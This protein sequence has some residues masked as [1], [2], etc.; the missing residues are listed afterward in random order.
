VSAPYHRAGEAILATI[1][2]FDGTET[3]ARSIARQRQVD[4][5]V[6]CRSSQETQALRREAPGGFLDQLAQ[7]QVPGWLKPVDEGGGT[8][9][10]I[11][12]VVRP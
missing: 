7:R 4:Y 11:F 8:A 1:R 2:A 6:F 9:L 3:D 12:H 10:R 5:V